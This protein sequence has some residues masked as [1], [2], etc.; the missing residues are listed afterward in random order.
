MK[1]GWYNKSPD[2]GAKRLMKH[3]DCYAIFFFDIVLTR[4]I[5]VP[6]RVMHFDKMEKEIVLHSFFY[7]GMTRRV[8]RGQMESVTSCLLGGQIGYIFFGMVFLHVYANKN[9][10]IYYVF[11]YQNMEEIKIEDKQKQ[12]RR[13]M[14]D[15]EI[16]DGENEIW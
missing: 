11:K 8:E 6:V 2:I 12:I 10:T 7:L 9:G 4:K 5:K 1:S 15:T 16:E 13:H 14:D 3:G